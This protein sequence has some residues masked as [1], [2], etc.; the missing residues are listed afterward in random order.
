MSVRLIPFSP[1]EA[2]VV[3][4]RPPLPPLVSPPPAFIRKSIPSVFA[5]ANTGLNFPLRARSFEFEF[6]FPAFPK[7]EQKERDAVSASEIEI[8]FAVPP[9]DGA[10][11]PPVVADF[12]PEPAD[13]FG[14]K[15]FVPPT[16]PAFFFPLVTIPGNN[17]VKFA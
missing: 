14:S 10:N 16:E 7:V 8:K 11:L 13:D 4:R 12:S 5:S 3:D 2:V 9:I 17:G 1:F 15:L 6:E